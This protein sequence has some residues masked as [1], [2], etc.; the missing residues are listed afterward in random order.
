MPPLEIIRSATLTVSEVLG[1]QDDLG[2][3]AAAKLADM[4]AVP[5]D[6][7]QDITWID[8]CLS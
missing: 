3:L 5:G 7:S 8:I 6:P 4:V 1:V 2:T